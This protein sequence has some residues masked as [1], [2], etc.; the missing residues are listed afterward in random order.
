MFYKAAGIYLALRHYISYEM[1]WRHVGGSSVSALRP[2]QP[3]RLRFSFT[4]NSSLCAST[5]PSGT[6]TTFNADGNEDRFV[7]NILPLGVWVII[8]LI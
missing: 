5:Q 1:T 2:V 6:A 4:I 3:I 7:T 8:H